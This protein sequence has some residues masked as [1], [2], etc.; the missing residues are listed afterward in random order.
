MVYSPPAC[1]SVTS[2]A[3]PQTLSM[4]CVLA[5]VIVS[6]LGPLISTVARFVPMSGVW[7]FALKSTPRT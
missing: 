7:P 6:P 3:K 4:I 1:V 2:H 5:V